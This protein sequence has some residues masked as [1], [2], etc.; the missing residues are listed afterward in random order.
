MRDHRRV[1][2]RT[3]AE[4]GVLP[5]APHPEL[6]RFARINGFDV[7]DVGRTIAE[8]CERAESRGADVDPLDVLEELKGFA[9]VRAGVLGR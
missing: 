8:T 2:A 7:D 9:A 4:E 6:V 5:T 3:L 1:L